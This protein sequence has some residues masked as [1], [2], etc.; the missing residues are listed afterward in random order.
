MKRVS[1][2]HRNIEKNPI[3]NENVNLGV[4]CS[5]P[6]YMQS[7]YDQYLC[8]LTFCMPWAD[9]FLFRSVPR[10]DFGPMYIF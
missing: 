7:A 6:Q 10:A 3:L 2:L 5:Q 4:I 9:L 1:N 8:L